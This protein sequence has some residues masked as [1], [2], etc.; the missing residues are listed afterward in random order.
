MA[1]VT[2]HRSQVGSLIPMTLL[3]QRRFSSLVFT[4]VCFLSE[5]MP[6]LHYSLNML[7]IVLS[8]GLKLESFISTKL[9]QEEFF[10]LHNII[11]DCKVDTV[12]WEGP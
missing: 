4:S 2:A 3:V 5:P 11:D 1:I 12:F 10:P 8:S 6:C 7:S 9:G